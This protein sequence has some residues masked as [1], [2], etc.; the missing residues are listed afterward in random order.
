MTKGEKGENRC[1]SDVRAPARSAFFFFLPVLVIFSGIL[2]GRWKFG[3]EIKGNLSKELRAQVMLEKVK[4]CLLGP[5]LISSTQLN[6]A[7]AKICSPS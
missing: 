6:L 5:S 4:G 2:V 3:T 1:V 7:A